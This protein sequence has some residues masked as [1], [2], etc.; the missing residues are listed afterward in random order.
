MKYRF[1]VSRMTERVFL[2]DLDS[3]KNVF[4]MSLED[5]VE[6]SKEHKR[7]IKELKKIN[8]KKK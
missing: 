4:N 3:G 8:S 6:F 5:F 2:T 1:H 7:F